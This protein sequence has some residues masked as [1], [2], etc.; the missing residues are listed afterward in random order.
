M[1]CYEEV[2]TLQIFEKPDISCDPFHKLIRNGA[3][4]LI[5]P[6]PLKLNLK[7]C[8][9]SHDEYI[10]LSTWH[11]YPSFITVIYLNEL[12]R[13]VLEMLRLKCLR[14]GLRISNGTCFN[15]SFLP[16]YLKRIKSGKELLSWL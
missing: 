8:C 2:S 12:Y 7:P 9:G 10:A 16:H 13:L 4:Q 6:P 14:L 5:G 11:P 1:I 3:R 15:S